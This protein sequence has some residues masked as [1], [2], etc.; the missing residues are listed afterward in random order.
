MIITHVLTNFKT[1]KMINTFF[2][3]SV[4][5]IAPVKIEKRDNRIATGV[6][7][8]SLIKM[9]AKKEGFN[10]TPGGLRRWVNSWVDVKGDNTKERDD[11]L[12][13]LSELLVYRSGYTIRYR[14]KAP[15]SAKIVQ[16]SPSK[17]GNVVVELKEAPVLVSSK[18]L[19]PI[20]KPEQLVKIK[21]VVFKILID[22]LKPNPIY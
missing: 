10:T 1:Y 5:D 3:Y 15:K 14:L 4:T 21:N 19:R 2:I 12:N 17:S 6:T 13:E 16:K 8:L 11:I 20:V 18:E 7:A 22:L 9:Q